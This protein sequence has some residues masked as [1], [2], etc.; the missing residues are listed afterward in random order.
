MKKLNIEKNKSLKFFNAYFIKTNA[1]YFYEFKGNIS[2]L[3]QILRWASISN[4][5]VY[6]LGGGSNILVTKDKIDG[7][8]VYV[9][10]D[11][12]EVYDEKIRVSSGVDS[13]IFS[14]FAYVNGLSK[15]EF[16]YGLPGKIGGAI[17]M[18]ARVYEN[19][20]SDILKKSRVVTYSGEIK[21]LENKDMNFGYKD[22]IFQHK[23]Y[24][25]IDS[26]FELKKGDKGD[27][28]KQM[29]Y[30]LK[31]R[32]KKGHFDYPSCGSVFKN[33]LMDDIYAGELIDNLNLKGTSIGTAEIFD[34]HG[35]FIINKNEANG[36]DIQKL[37]S[38]IQK[39]VKEM[40]DIDLE[41]EVVIW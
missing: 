34:K 27:I 14:I 7:L 41:K 10:N 25:I 1:K 19:S 40:K 8:V 17:Y 5:D 2:E 23:N 13:S 6:I 33:S 28:L 4:E 29:D 16:L 18:N 15:T 31:Q 9:N 39:K 12:I 24:I 38:Y 22:S 3:Q 32:V 35:N 21:E 20:I 37:I 26:E 11:D 30:N 36:K